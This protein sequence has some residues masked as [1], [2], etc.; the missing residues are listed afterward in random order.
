MNYFK[1]NNILS[2]KLNSYDLSY[3]CVKAKSNLI[4]KRCNNFSKTPTFNCK[5][6]RKEKL[7][8]YKLL[9]MVKIMNITEK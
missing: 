7:K 2:K 5:K 6:L 3:K 1:K 8:R 9:E 4:L